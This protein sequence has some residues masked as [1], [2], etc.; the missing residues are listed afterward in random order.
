V[1]WT[2][3][4]VVVVAGF[5]VVVTGIVDV[6]LVI[7]FSVVVA[8]V[9]V[10]ASVVVVVAL[11]VDGSLDPHPPPS[12]QHTSSCQLKFAVQQS[13]SVSYFVSHEAKA[14]FCEQLSVSLKYLRS[15]S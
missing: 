9:V 5:S 12:A 2:V 6:V 1:V 11:V 14:V 3:D 10:V 15:P 7:G 4:E 13:R 8:D